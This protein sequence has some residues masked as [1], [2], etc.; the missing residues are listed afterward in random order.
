MKTWT[1]IKKGKPR[2]ICFRADGTYYP[3]YLR[4]EKELDWFKLYQPEENNHER[5]SRKE[6]TSCSGGGSKAFN[7]SAEAEVSESL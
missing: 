6:V 1:V 4:P 2:K 5:N 3:A 7:T